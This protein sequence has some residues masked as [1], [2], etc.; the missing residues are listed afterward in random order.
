MPNDASPARIGPGMMSE[1]NLARRIAW[2]MERRGWSQE[3]MAK[4]MTDAGYPLHQSSVS[5]IVNPKD[6]KRRAI[7]V[8]DALGFAHVFGIDLEELLI[9]LEAAWDT[10]LRALLGRLEHL[11]QQRATLDRDTVGVVTQIVKL[12]QTTGDD[13]LDERMHATDAATRQILLT[14]LE[15][16]GQ[17]MLTRLAQAGPADDL[18]DTERLEQLHRILFGEQPAT[19]SPA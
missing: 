8:D 5:K 14:E 11:H 2:E 4:E 3:R 19:G 10:E 6:G 15:R 12:L 7:S 18:T 9:P 13:Q 1:G 16:W 17:M